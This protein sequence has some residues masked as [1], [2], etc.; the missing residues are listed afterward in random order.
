[1][2]DE[3][4]TSLHG[5]MEILN[6]S[7]ERSEW[8]DANRFSYRQ[9][10]H[11]HCLPA[12]K[13]RNVNIFDLLFYF[14]DQLCVAEP[15]TF[16]REVTGYNPHIT[17]GLSVQKPSLRELEPNISMAVSELVNEDEGVILNVN[18][19]S[20]DILDTIPLNRGIYVIDYFWTPNVA[21]GLSHLGPINEQSVSFV[22]SKPEIKDMVKRYWTRFDKS[23]GPDHFCAYS[24]RG[25]HEGASSLLSKIAILTSGERIG[26][27]DKI[28][29]FMENNSVLAIDNNEYGWGVRITTKELDR[30]DI[31]KR[32]YKVLN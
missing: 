18:L 16:G 15:H 22:I 14:N 12:S 24:V 23:L 25:G 31:V 2:S 26:K 10:T 19:P 7:D 29:D 4:T 21:D 28:R 11:T 1:M 6:L 9:R 5:A 20:R 30:K 13:K 8:I 27:R 3:I 32:L 17:S